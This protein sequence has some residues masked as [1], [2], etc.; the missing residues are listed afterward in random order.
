MNLC[1]AH[2]FVYRD[3]SFCD[4]YACFTCHPTVAHR[5]I[6]ACRARGITVVEEPI[7]GLPGFF[8]RYRHRYG[9]A[10][11]IL[12]FAVIVFFS[13][14][15]VW[16][17][18][19]EGNE[20]LDDAEVI[21]AL[22]EQGLHV[23]SVY[24]R[25]DIDALENRVLLYADDLSWLSINMIGTVANVELREVELAPPS[26][27]QYAA[28]DLV[29]AR[30]G[31]IEWFEDVRGNVAVEIGEA[32]GEGDLLVGGLYGSE[33]KPAHYTCAQGKVFART[34]RTFDVE[35]LLTYEKKVYTGRTSVEKYLIF[36]EK[37]VKFFTNS[38][39]SPLSC[40]TIDTVEYFQT[41]GGSCL[42]IGIRTVRHYEYETVSCTR[43]E[44][45]AM[46][47][48]HDTL[49]YSFHIELDADAMLVRK[50]T[51]AEP[52]EGSFVLHA[53]MEYIENI[54]KVEEIKIEGIPSDTRG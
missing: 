42:P 39:N 43:S 22:H 11:G 18:R 51:Y 16:E 45:E 27:P 20:R 13:G 54:A 2:G 12:L 17:I 6:E 23:G 44:E 4:E 3:F 32:V 5:L 52:R 9:I 35:I 36:F 26:P 29:A 30:G 24:S 19:V 33:G 28:A 37:E 8:L 38:R 41:H 14:Q 31:V 10:L 46:T 15:V 48:A 50:R 25:L 21:A 40:D 47:L 34:E 53:R 49:R 7:R 1:H